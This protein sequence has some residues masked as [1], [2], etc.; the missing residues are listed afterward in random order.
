MNLAASGIRRTRLGGPLGYA[1]LCA[2]V[3]MTVAVAVQQADL[4]QVAY[5][6]PSDG[7]GEKSSDEYDKEAKYDRSSDEY[8]KEAK[9]DE[10][11]SD[12]Y[13]KHAMHLPPLQQDVAPS[14]VQCNEPR[15]LYLAGSRPMCLYPATYDV[16]LARGMD[17]VEVATGYPDVGF[18][19]EEMAWLDENPVVRVSYDPHWYPIEYEDESGELAGVTAK[20]LYKF[21][22]ITGAEFVPV[23]TA[24]WTAALDSI[25][26]RTSD[27]IMMVTPTDERSEYMAFTTGHYPVGSSLVTLEDVQLDMDEDVYRVLTVRNYSIEEWLDENHPDIEYVSADNT[28]H[29]LQLLQT[30]EAD[31]FATYWPVAKGIADR[32]GITVYN[33]GPTG[34]DQPLAIGYRD[35]LPVLGGI[36]QKTLD[37]IPPEMLEKIQ[38]IETPAMK[39][40]PSS[41]PTVDLTAEEQAWLDENPVVRVSYDPHWYPIEYED[42]SGELAGVTAKY[43]YKFSK[44]TGAEFMAAD[45][46]DWTAALDSIRDRTSDVIMLVAPTDERSEYM[47]FT[48]EHY[49]VETSLVTLEDV[50]LDMDEDVFRV[51]TIYNYEVEDWLDENHPGIEY[52]SVDNTLHGLQMLQTGEAD[53]FAAT[54]EVAKSIAEREG[55]TVYNAGP[56]GHAYHLA[57]G[58]RDDLPV[59]G[60]ILQKVLDAIPPE[61]LEKMQ[62]IDR[63]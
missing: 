12:K 56:T 13:G 50:Q 8:D 23:D 34:H 28:L 54:W 15:N 21:S 5:A 17:L 44:I 45:T 35:D 53:V 18:T 40:T 63:D 46:A 49:P 30:G 26:D 55:I 60:D 33:A 59:L 16:L 19:A 37:H 32:E 38:S 57:I 39:L 1:V 20:Y 22:K 24:D 2:A 10:H 3:V 7:Y 25:R 58:Y 29:G 27:V 51:L 52:V 11:S 62:R 43:M 6:Y 14:E 47:A 42:E 9:Y 61:L 41:Y 48:T 4:E 36:L 31:V